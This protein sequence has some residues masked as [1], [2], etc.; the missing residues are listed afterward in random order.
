MCA[1]FCPN[2]L[3]F[4]RTAATFICKDN[5]FVL[6]SNEDS[7]ISTVEIYRYINEAI[8]MRDTME[9]RSTICLFVYLLI[10]WVVWII[11]NLQ[12]LQANYHHILPSILQFLKCCSLTFE[13]INPSSKSSINRSHADSSTST[14]NSRLLLIQLHENGQ[15]LSWPCGCSLCGLICAYLHETA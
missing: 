7:H 13:G 9:A 8:V 11:V 2:S 6:L 5:F 4:L 15:I 1:A 3:K 12:K 14:E 10:G